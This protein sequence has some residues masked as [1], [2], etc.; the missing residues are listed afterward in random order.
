[1]LICLIIRDICRDIITDVIGTI[2]DSM[3]DSVIMDEPGDGIQDELGNYI[4]AEI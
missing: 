2:E 1:M 4:E 3:S